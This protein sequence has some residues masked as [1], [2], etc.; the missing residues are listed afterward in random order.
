MSGDKELQQALTTLHDWTLAL[1]REAGQTE[2]TAELLWTKI[3]GAPEILREYAYYHD[4]GEALCEYSVHGYTLADIMVWQI[5]HFRSHM[6]RMD[7]DNK[8]NAA[9][10]L[11][12]SFVCMIKLRD[13]PD[14]VINKFAGETGTDLASGWTIG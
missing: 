6:D 7:N 2:D 3:K 9:S 12:D 8:R 5:D 4:R 1:A 11:F 14:E 10:L 13:N